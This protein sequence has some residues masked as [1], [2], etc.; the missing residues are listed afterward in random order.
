MLPTSTVLLLPIYA[1]IY[2]RSG[3]PG[4]P[5]PQPELL[6]AVSRS[7]PKKGEVAK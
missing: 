6:A 7:L 2:K 5:E 3:S 1:S 4:G